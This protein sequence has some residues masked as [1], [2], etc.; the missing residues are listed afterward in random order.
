MLIFEQQRLYV[1]F[2]HVLIKNECNT[3][4]GGV[5]QL[6]PIQIYFPFLNIVEKFTDRIVKERVVGLEGG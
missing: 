3:F 4:K 6:S 1:L 5:F 2:C